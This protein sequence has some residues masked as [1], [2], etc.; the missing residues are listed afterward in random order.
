MLTSRIPD[1]EMQMNSFFKTWW[2][3]RKTLREFSRMQRDEEARVVLDETN[4]LRRASIALSMNDTAEAL[5]CWKIF[6]TRFPRLAV[7]QPESLSVMLGLGLYEEAE[8]LMTSGLRA[9]PN[10]PDIA[11]G[12]AQIAQKRGKFAEAVRQ[13]SRLRKRFPA[14]W[15]G[16]TWGAEALI[17]LG[18]ADEAEKLAESSLALFPDLVYCWIHAAKVAEAGQKWDLALQRWDYVETEFRNV[19]GAIGATKALIK[20]GRHDG[21]RNRLLSL[22]HKYS[23]DLEFRRLLAELG[24]RQD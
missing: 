4:L 9:Y 8:Q 1:G 15:K 16:Y 6:R 3:R 5:R 24:I 13:W 22:R 10:N 21:A 19:S 14:R 20:M 7:V 18:R 17:E 12:L 23:G 2:I 11:E